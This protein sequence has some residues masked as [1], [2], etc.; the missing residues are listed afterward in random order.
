MGWGWGSPA[1]I[2]IVVVVHI[3]TFM[4]TSLFK[5]NSNKQIVQV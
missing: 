1:T 4:T 5:F 2:I 3:N